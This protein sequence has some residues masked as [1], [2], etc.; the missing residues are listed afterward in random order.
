MAGHKMSFTRKLSAVSTITACLLA[1]HAT[2]AEERPAIAIFETAVFTD[3]DAVNATAINSAIII[4]IKKLKLFRII[5][6]SKVNAVL[7]KEMEGRGSCRDYECLA[8][9]ASQVG[10]DWFAESDIRQSGNKCAFTIRLHLRQRG[11]PGFTV[12][13]QMSR[14]F[15]CSTSEMKKGVRI[16]LSGFADSRKG[17]GTGKM[18][19]LKAGEFI[20]GCAEAS[21][22][23]CPEREKPAHR[24]YLDAYFMDE[25]TVKVAEYRK[26][27]NESMCKAPYTKEPC[28][29]VIP[30]REEKPMNCLDW[31]NA[32]AYCTWAGKRLPTEAEWENAMR[33]STERRKPEAWEWTA[34]WYGEKYF[35]ESPSKNPP[36]PIYGS[37]RVLRGSAG[38]FYNPVKRVVPDR[39]R[40]N[41]ALPGGFCRCAKSVSKQN[42]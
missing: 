11:G 23:K 16:F 24:V 2:P 31:H 25:E 19:M 28:N 38:R 7:K 4:G 13:K 8:G 20:M 14:D 33:F 30:G 12:E 5:S 39:Q 9:V 42:E 34:D 3:G 17:R 1:A 35:G 10:A 27:V 15:D 6:A 21:G 18:F 37:E 22:G 36:G 41:P 29:W 26:C 32:D 40:G